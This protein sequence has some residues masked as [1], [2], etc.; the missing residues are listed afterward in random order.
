M[1]IHVALV[2]D[3]AG[4]RAELTGF[5][6]QYARESG[7]KFHITAFSDGAEIVDR[8]SA[9]YQLILMDIEM[10]TMDGMTA[11]ERIREL[12]TEVVI[13]FI[14]NM[15]Q[16]VM[17]GYTVDALDYVLKPVSYFAFSQRIS[18][19]LERMGRRQRRFITIP[20][21]SGMQKLDMGEITYVEV[22]NHSL[23]YHTQRDSYECKGTLTNV[24]AQLEGAPFFRISNCY[25]INLEYVDSVQNSDAVVAGKVLAVSRARKKPLLDALNDYINEVSK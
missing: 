18:R 24:A 10:N 6:E 3:D 7:N 9:D 4:Y 20:I 17:K 21:H 12:D 22:I 1:T 25:L 14:T 16:Y 2:E 5:L 8:Y 11:A 19:A 15:P 23:I 13:I